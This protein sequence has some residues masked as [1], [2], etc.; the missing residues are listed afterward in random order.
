MSKRE[1]EDEVGL[2][3]GRAGGREVLTQASKEAEG[4]S[5]AGSRLQ[6]LE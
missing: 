4:M 2:G 3:A 6:N 5:V 1:A